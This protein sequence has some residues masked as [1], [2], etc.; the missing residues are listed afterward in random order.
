MSLPFCTSRRKYQCFW[1]TFWSLLCI[2]ITERKK[3]KKAKIQVTWETLYMYVFLDESRD[4]KWIGEWSTA[5]KLEHKKLRFKSC[6]LSVA[7]DQV[8]YACSNATWRL[9][10]K[11]RLDFQMNVT[12]ALMAKDKSCIQALFS[13]SVYSLHF[14]SLY[15]FFFFEVRFRLLA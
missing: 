13:F 7:Q 3:K 6:G 5:V 15:F 14:L 9:Q 12:C 11:F 4:K 1:H 8:E 10:S 2:S